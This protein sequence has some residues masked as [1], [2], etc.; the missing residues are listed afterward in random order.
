MFTFPVLRTRNMCSVL[1]CVEMYVIL[2]PTPFEISDG[3]L[4]DIFEKDVLVE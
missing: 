1:L 3:G 4:G 2:L